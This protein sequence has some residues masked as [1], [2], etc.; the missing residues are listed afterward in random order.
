MSK[1]IYYQVILAGFH[2]FDFHFYKSK[3]FCIF[4]LLTCD[5]KSGKTCICLLDLLLFLCIFKYIYEYIG[6]HLKNTR[7]MGRIGF[8]LA[9]NYIVRVSDMV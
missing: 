2:I 5:D 1:C 4:I 3:I 7:I 9:T 8:A 6:I